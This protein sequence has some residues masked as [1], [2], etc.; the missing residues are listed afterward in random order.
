MGSSI[1]SPLT[2]GKKLKLAIGS[3]SQGGDFV[4]DACGPGLQL[5]EFD[6]AAGKLCL[7]STLDT[8]TNS[9]YASFDLSTGLLYVIAEHFESP[10]EVFCIRVEDGT[11][12]WRVPSIGRASCHI[13]LMMDRKSFCACSYLDSSMAQFAADGSEL[14]RFRYSGSGPNRERQEHSHPHQVLHSPEGKWVLVPDLGSDC[15]WVHPLFE[16]VVQD[17]VEASIQMPAGSGPRHGI[18]LNTML[19]LLCELNAMAYA[20]IWDEVTGSFAMRSACSIFDTS[21]NGKPAASALRRHPRLPLIY[22][23]ERSTNTITAIE[24]ARDGG[25][26]PVK[27]FSVGGKEPRDFEIIGDEW[28]LVVC[29]SSHQINGIPLNRTTGLPRGESIQ[30]ARTRTPNSI[31]KL[32]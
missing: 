9:S 13:Q 21:G 23:A 20:G 28:L 22:A 27:T 3:Y 17:P 11:V 12:V 24:V 29:Q 8:L 31:C 19:C 7:N 16:G 10:G 15:L 26:T 2:V 32:H 1:Q 18:F 4:P 6:P 14:R 25:L 5:Y 30:L